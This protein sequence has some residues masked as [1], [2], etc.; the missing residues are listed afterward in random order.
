MIKTG[1]AISPKFDSAQC[2]AVRKAVQ[3]LALEFSQGSRKLLVP[4]DLTPDGAAILTHWQCQAPRV[5]DLPLAPSR[6]IVG[7]NLRVRVQADAPYQILET[8]I[9]VKGIK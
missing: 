2:F 4:S 1:C 6:L 8:L 5:L 9:R 7:V 3:L